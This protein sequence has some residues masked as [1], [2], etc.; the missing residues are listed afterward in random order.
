[1]FFITDYLKQYKNNFLTVL[2]VVF[3]VF[4]AMS[5]TSPD[6]FAVGKIITIKK[7][8]TIKSTA[9]ILKKENIIRSELIF[10]LLV[11]FKN[12][13]VVE[14]TYLFHTPEN[15]FKIVNRVIRGSYQ[16][17]IEKI[18]FIEGDTSKEIADKIK[19]KIQNFDVNLFSEL[20]RANEGYLFP[21]TYEFQQT[22]SAQEVIKK[23]RDNFDKKTKEIK[24][25][26]EKS[27]HSLE[28]IVKMASI[29]EGEADA[30]NMQQIS[31]IL[32]RRYDLDMPLQVDAT[33]VY[34]I[35]KSS[36]DLTTDDLKD[37]NNPYNSYKFKGLPPT[38]IS[39]PGLK[40]LA[41]AA[42]KQKTPYLYFLTGRDGNTYYASS[43][44][45][46]KQNRNLYLD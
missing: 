9:G 38:P 43:F 44:E 41:A 18:T 20:A 17:P 28:E 16:I 37:E 15:I 30:E 7:G 11:I 40:S 2:F 33:F 32:W 5:T 42:N 29:L 3:F 23:M 19:N 1:M 36:F 12:D 35:N 8:E 26:L 13:N 21:D 24:V 10:N 45:K 6:N 39:N 27:E 25:L 22:I 31:D 34:S 4:L 46:H 14:G